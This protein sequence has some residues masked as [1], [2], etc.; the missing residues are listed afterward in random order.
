MSSTVPSGHDLFEPDDTARPRDEAYGVLHINSDKKALKT[1][2]RN[3]FVQ[4]PDELQQVMKIYSPIF[5]GSSFSFT[6]YSSPENWSTF[7][8]DSDL[9]DSPLKSIDTAPPSAKPSTAIID[10]SSQQSASKHPASNVNAN[11]FD[12]ARF[13]NLKALLPCS[14]LP[15]VL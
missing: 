4:G 5:P 8:N 1:P 10:D 11:V 3:I 9:T 14:R 13:V 2:L 12:E 6:P 7:Y 15:L